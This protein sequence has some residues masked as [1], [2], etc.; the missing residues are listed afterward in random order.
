MPEIEIELFLRPDDVAPEAMLIFTTAPVEVQMK[1][2]PDKP[3]KTVLQGEV[4]ISGGE[5]RLWTINKTSHIAL[6]TS[7]G[8]NTDNW[9]GKPFAVF[10]TSMNVRG[11][12]K[13]VI[14][15]RV[16]KKED[17]SKKV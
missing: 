1:F 5:R 16:P 6:A 15:A 9:L 10:V 11:K 4:Q 14:M 12:Q 2:E 3:E 8:K 13:D 17:D 7:W